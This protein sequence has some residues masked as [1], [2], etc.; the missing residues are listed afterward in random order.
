MKK[1]FIKGMSLVCAVIMAFSLASCGKKTNKTTTGAA[2]AAASSTVANSVDSSVTAATSA[3][4]T[5]ATKPGET[6]KALTVPKSTAE[7]V[8]LYTNAANKTKSSA[9]MTIGRTDKSTF[10]IT[11]I[12]VGSG[13][14]PAGLR[15]KING[16]ISDGIYPQESSYTY[17]YNNGTYYMERNADGKTYCE[18]GQ[19]TNYFSFKNGM[20][21]KI[22]SS[23]KGVSK[24]AANKELTK[25]NQ[26]VSPS[27]EFMPVSG[28]SYHSQLTASDV[29]NATYSKKGN[30][31]VV[32]L[33]LKS[34]KNPARGSGSV[35]KCMNPI[36]IAT[37]KNYKL[38]AGQ[39]NTA[40]ANFANSY[41][42]AEINPDG[43]LVSEKLSWS[44]TFVVTGKLVVSIDGTGSAGY[45]ATFN[46]SN[47]GTTKVSKPSWA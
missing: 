47:Y 3:A 21:K 7:A 22:T 34:C 1:K 38:P 12:H 33:N 11:N 2:P 6:Q 42:E 4:T 30:D 44:A 19:G 40:D 29:A 46:F 31:V 26:G 10:G 20:F 9:N 39:V 15:D 41:I 24:A 32:R 18:Y 45:T 25:S 37:I 43:L 36:E 5:A 23:M 16:I 8:A 28:L 13:T 14:V 27:N 17:K 35:G